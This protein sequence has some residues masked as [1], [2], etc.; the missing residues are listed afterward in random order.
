MRFDR[1]TELVSLGLR[2]SLLKNR[3]V[4]LGVPEVGVGGVIGSGEEGFEGWPVSI[5][6]VIVVDLVVVVAEVAK[7]S[8]I[9]SISG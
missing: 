5:V 2:F 7:V 8:I 1:V 9:L 3:I 4:L 6:A